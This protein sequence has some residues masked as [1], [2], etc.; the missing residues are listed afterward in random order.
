MTSNPD[1]VVQAA[2]YLTNMNT[3]YRLFNAYRCWGGTIARAPGDNIESIG[4][5]ETFVALAHQWGCALTPLPI[6]GGWGSWTVD[7]NSNCTFDRTFTSCSR[8][9]IRYCDYPLPEFGGAACVGSDIQTASCPCPALDG[10]YSDWGSWGLCSGRPACSQSRTRTCTNPAPVSGGANC[11]HLG[12]AL[13]SRLC[14][15]CSSDGLPQNIESDQMASLAASQ[16]FMTAA[17]CD[18]AHGDAST[19]YWPAVGAV[20]GGIVAGFIL[21]AG[22]H[23]V[24]RRKQS[25]SPSEVHPVVPH[26]QEIERVGSPT[27]S[28][29]DLV[30]IHPMMLDANADAEGQPHPGAAFSWQVPHDRC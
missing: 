11:S 10:G 4:S 24:C 20:I 27:P 6:A 29:P 17:Q 23:F 21:F 25:S 16:G 30:S 28:C 1:E 19:S 15:E 8:S 7:N 5:R 14:S 26:H 13:E 18:Q 3:L 22:L 12:P 2:K 9:E